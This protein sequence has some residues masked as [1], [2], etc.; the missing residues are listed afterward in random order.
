MQSLSRGWSFLT[1][2]WKMAR[3]DNDLIK[4][5][6]YALFV[7]FFVS[8]IGIIPMAL[9]AF[10]FGTDKID[11]T[12]HPRCV[13]NAAGLCAIFRYLCFLGH[14]RL[15]DLRLPHRRRRAH[16]QGL[17]HGPARLAGYL[18]SLA[19]ASTLVSIV[20]PAGCGSGRSRNFDPR[21]ALPA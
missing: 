13:W 7:G 20:R 19:A 16:G 8:L 2:A 21:M 1:E 15:S 6:I 4:P 12:C 9:A 5:S 10:I 3:A 11:R 18:L 17:G 14:D